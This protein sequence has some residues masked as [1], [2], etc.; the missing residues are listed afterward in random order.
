LGWS[1]LGKCQC[2]LGGNSWSSVFFFIFSMLKI[3]WNL[4]WKKKKINSQISLE[5]KNSKI[6]PISLLK[7][8]KISPEKEKHWGKVEN[9]PNLVATNFR[10]EFLLRILW[11]S[12][13]GD[14]PENILAKFGYILDIKVEKKNQN[15]LIFLATTETYD[16]NLANAEFY[17]LKIW[18][19]WVFFVN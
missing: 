8:S 11:C 3:W 2:G 18:Q 12:Q 17:F 19:I 14:H 6:F 9:Q 5:E 7:N 10:A 13:S 1:E 15:P 16:K 4:T